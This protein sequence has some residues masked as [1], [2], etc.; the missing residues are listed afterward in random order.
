MIAVNYAA[1]EF[2]VKRDDNPKEA[3]IKCPNIRLV[4]VATYEEGDQEAK[5]HEKPSSF[6]HKVSLEHY[7]KEVFI[8][9]MHSFFFEGKKAKNST[10][11]H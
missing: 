11:F 8:S 1:R 3:L 2:G 4:H 5:Y 6:T 9:F 10:L 7:R